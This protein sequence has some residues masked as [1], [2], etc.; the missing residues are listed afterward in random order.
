MGVERER[1]I[2]ELGPVHTGPQVLSL[3]S[4]FVQ[5]QLLRAQE[6]GLTTLHRVQVLS[7]CHVSIQEVRLGTYVQS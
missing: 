5:S 6:L 1:K 3:V 2:C 4:Q 7:C